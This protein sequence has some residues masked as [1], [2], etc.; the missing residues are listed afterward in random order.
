[1]IGL[2][3]ESRGIAY[4]LILVA[5]N[6]DTVSALEAAEYEMA[7]GNILEVL[8]EYEVEQGA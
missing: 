6:V 5:Y 8:H 1:M 4:F 2:P 7:T 3:G